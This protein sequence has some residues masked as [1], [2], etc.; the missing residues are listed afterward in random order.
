MKTVFF[1]IL[2]V[3][4]ASAVAES[5]VNFYVFGGLSIYQEDFETPVTKVGE[6]V[7]YRGGIGAQLNTTLGLEFIYD[8]APA[9]NSG[10]LHRK[11]LERDSEERKYLYTSLAGTFTFSNAGSV[12]AVMKF[13]LSHSTAE[14]NP[15][16]FDEVREVFWSIGLKIDVNKQFALEFSHNHTFGETEVRFFSG[17]LRFD[18]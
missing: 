7:G 17:I 6:G 8:R 1:F 3:F 11:P 12:S 9:I 13:G 10:T 2:L 16:N 5:K 18:F 4:S 14:I 15:L